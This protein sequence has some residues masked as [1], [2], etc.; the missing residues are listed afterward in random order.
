MKLEG[1]IDLFTGVI[2]SGNYAGARPGSRGAWG[3]DDL[4]RRLHRLPV[5]RGR[6]EPEIRLPH[7]QHPVG[8]RHHGSDR[9]GAGMA[10]CSQDRPH[11]S[12]LQLRPQR[13]RALH[14]RGRAAAAR[15]QVVSES[16]PKLGT[17]DF[18]SHITKILS[19]EP[20]LLYTSVWGGDYVAFYKQALRYGLFDKMKVATTLA[21]GV[22][23]HAIGK[24]H[25]E[26][27][28]A[29]VHSNYSLHLSGRRSLAGQQA[30]RAS[31]TSS[32]G[33]NIRTS[34]RKAP[35]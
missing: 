8:G 35:M 5:R 28:L 12:G 9:R 4:H 33:T 34:S 21:F 23:P 26:G 7:H 11:P 32:A 20:D 27:V 10:A 2:S 25:P 6:S 1:K 19:S 31:A 14:A 29:G 24:D 17:T 13:F 18:T 22:A 30:I 3:A 16:W 15:H